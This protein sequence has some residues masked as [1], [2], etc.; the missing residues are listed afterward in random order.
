MIHLAQ[1][2][3][4][5]LGVAM[6][7]VGFKGGDRADEFT[8]TEFGWA[9]LFIAGLIVIVATIFWFLFSL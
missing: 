8:V 7:I 4:T 9:I 2:A 5:L 6:V 3:V 1:L